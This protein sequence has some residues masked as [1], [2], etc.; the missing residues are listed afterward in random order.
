MKSSSL[1]NH[2][3]NIHSD[4]IEK[5]EWYIYDLKKKYTAQTTILKLLWVSYKHDD[6]GLRVAHNIS[7]LIYQD[8]KP[9][10]IGE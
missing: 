1:Q 7:Y 4:T 6:D 9:H 8:G 2:L 5:Y 3:N 10:T